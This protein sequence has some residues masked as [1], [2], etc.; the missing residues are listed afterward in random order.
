[1]DKVTGAS[2]ARVSFFK[3]TKFEARL[4]SGGGA[5]SWRHEAHDNM[6]GVTAMRSAGQR[7][8]S[9]PNSCSL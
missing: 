6:V 3:K 2:N 7:V 4:R 9:V 5:A 1:M 8:S